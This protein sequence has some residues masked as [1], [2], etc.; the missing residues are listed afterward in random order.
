M[1]HALL[2][3]FI[4]FSLSIF[5]QEDPIL[6]PVHLREIPKYNLSIETGIT[7]PLG[8]YRI[9]ARSGSQLGVVGSWYLN[10]HWGLSLGLKRQNNTS[11][12]IE[13]TTQDRSGNFQSN[14]F[15]A[16]AVYSYTKNRF[17]IDGFV[18]AG[19]NQLNYDDEFRFYDSEFNNEGYTI[20]NDQT[21]EWAAAIELGLRFNYYFR[22]SVQ[23]F[24]S[25]QWHS[26]LNRPL[27]LVQTR[28][29]GTLSNNTPVHITNLSLN[30]GIKIA[31]NPIYSNGERRIDD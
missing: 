23:L 27:G 31:L 26:T 14:L 11:A 7:Q 21:E 25:P 12:L 1:K 9:A 24:V 18:R 13:S 15:T 17:Q 4:L 8:D 22:R 3:T 10:K 16:G 5:A 20:N 29:L 30:L 28:G 19:I 2:S 6:S